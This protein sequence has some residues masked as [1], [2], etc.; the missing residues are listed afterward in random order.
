MGY[1][2][3]LGI[4]VFILY[5]IS[6]SL[7]NSSHDKYDTNDEDDDFTDDAEDAYEDGFE[8]SPLDDVMY[9]NGMKARTISV[10][11][12]K[13]ERLE[14]KKYSNYDFYRKEK[15]LVIKSSFG[16]Y[17]EQIYSESVI[18]RWTTPQKEETVPRWLYQHFPQYD[19]TL[20]E[21]GFVLEH[22]TDEESACRDFMDGKSHVLNYVSMEEQAKRRADQKK[23]EEARKKSETKDRNARRDEY[24]EEYTGRAKSRDYDE[25]IKTCFAVLE[26]SPDSTIDDVKKAFHRLAQKFHPDKL[27]GKNLDQDFLDLAKKKFQELQSAY[28]ILME[29]FSKRG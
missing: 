8:P 6:N 9:I 26:L 20:R 13:T 28:E 23:S 1:L 24:R 15:S 21:N 7:V 12:E 27:E 10:A 2:I 22:S 29:Y 25:I 19:A 4:I 11:C 5:L 3:A 16:R 17:S 14:I 18:G